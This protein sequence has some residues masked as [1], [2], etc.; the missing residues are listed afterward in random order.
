MDY[1][2]D[3]DT[4]LGEYERYFVSINKFLTWEKKKPYIKKYPYFFGDT[5]IFLMVY[6]QGV[7]LQVT[8]FSE[9]IMLDSALLYPY[10]HPYIKFSKL[11]G[12]KKQRI[13][14]LRLVVNLNYSEEELVNCFSERIN[15][16][17]KKRPGQT[18]NRQKR[19]LDYD[20][21][22]KVYDTFVEKRDS[23][24]VIKG[25]RL[26]RRIAKAISLVKGGYRNIR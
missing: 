16:F 3:I 14:T 2:K 24:V 21:Y 6:D 26:R 18:I 20:C 23:K 19:F 9:D 8:D 17:K 25:R 12:L 10:G 22:L 11:A 13:N 15:Y 4:M 7:V 1:N 5:W